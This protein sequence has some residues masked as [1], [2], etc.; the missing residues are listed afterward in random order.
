MSVNPGQPQLKIVHKSTDL[1]DSQLYINQEL[2]WLQFNARVLEEAEDPTQPL[3][4]RVKFLSIYASNLD[5]F[6]MIRVSGLREQVSG[7][8]LEGPPDGMSPSEQLS[9]IRHELG[10]QLSRVAHCWENVLL[11]ELR[12][13]GIHILRYRQLQPNQQKMLRKYFS[14]EL[15]PALT[16]LAFDPSHPFP[17]I[18][19]LSF[20]PC[21]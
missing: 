12:D 8:V 3:L 5:E 10:P 9:A 6:F 16:P 19:I 2:S 1:D 17:H 15:F 14:Q 7:G 21:R 13:Q 4:E 11:P 20:K 18:S